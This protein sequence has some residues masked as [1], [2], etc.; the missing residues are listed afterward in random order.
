MTD[1]ETERLRQ[2]YDTTDLADELARAE[3]VEPSGGATM[4]GITIRLPVATLEAA[5]SMA[6]D[7]G[8]KVTALLREWVEQRVAERVDDTTVVPVAELRRLI[9]RASRASGHA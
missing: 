2:Y 7:D 4:V 8:V 3:L 5:R 9:A 1:D 6:R